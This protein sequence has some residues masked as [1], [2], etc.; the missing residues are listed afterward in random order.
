M[1]AAARAEKEQKE[2]DR[3]ERIEKQ[4]VAEARAAAQAAALNNAG[5][6]EK[7]TLY[8]Q[9]LADAENEG[10]KGDAYDFR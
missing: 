9:Y 8:A 6:K 4:K 3:L 7:I 10:R 2:R 1:E 5:I